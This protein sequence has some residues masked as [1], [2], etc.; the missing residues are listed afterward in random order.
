MP[1][2]LELQRVRINGREIVVHTAGQGE[3][4]VL[5]HGAG[6]FTGWDWIKPLAEGF[7]L[8][9]PVHPGYGE[10]EDDPRITSIQD[11]VMSYLDLFDELGL[12]TFNLVGHSLGGWMAAT[13]ATQHSRRLRKL[14]LASPVGLHVPE[15]PTLDIFRLEPEALLPK[16]VA[17]MRFFEGKLLNPPEIEVMVNSYRELSSTAR[18]AWERN[19]DPKLSRYLHRINVP[20]LLVWGEQDRLIPAVQAQVWASHIATAQVRI[21]PDVGHLV[22]EESP[23]GMQIVKEFL[24]GA[25]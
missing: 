8:I 24:A 19:Y 17:D 11:Y 25:V 2:T 15:A 7:R 18:I 5:W 16:L 20:T 6:T 4:V 9:A 10:S 12:D 3:P 23:M 13:F 22:L 21:V 14:V 1:A